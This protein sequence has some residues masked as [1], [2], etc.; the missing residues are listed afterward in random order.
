MIC[1][2]SVDFLNI[3]FACLSQKITLVAETKYCEEC[4]RLHSGLGGGGGG[5]RERGRRG[6]VFQYCIVSIIMSQHPRFML[7]D[8]LVGIMVKVSASRAEDP[9]FESQFSAGL[10]GSMFWASLKFQ[11]R[12]GCPLYQEDEEERGIGG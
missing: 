8:C 12:F 9:G 11:L 10:Q 7:S 3:R 1:S 2:I 5:G 6:G 4:A